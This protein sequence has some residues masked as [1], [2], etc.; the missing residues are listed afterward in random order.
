MFVDSGPDASREAARALFQAAR[1]ER[2]S[3]PATTQSLLTSSGGFRDVVASRARPNEAG[4]AAAAAPGV[5]SI[6]VS[7]NGT[8]VTISWTPSSS[9]DP[10]TSFVLKYSAP[11][12]V[13]GQQ[14][15]SARTVTFGGLSPGQYQ[16]Q[17]YATNSAGTTCSVPVAGEFTIVNAPAVPDPPT[18]LGYSLDGGIVTISWLIASTGAPPITLVVLAEGLGEFPVGLSGGITTSG[19]MPP[20]TYVVRV[21]ARNASGDSRP[22]GPISV[23]VPCTPPAAPQLSKSVSGSSVT[24][25]WS[26]GSPKIYTSSYVVTIS[27]PSPSQ[28]SVGSGTLTYTASSL[29]P[30]DY[31][32]T[33]Q[34]TSGGSC[35]GGAVSTVSFTITSTSQATFTGSFNGT[36][37]N[38]SGSCTWDVN[39]NGTATLNLTLQP[40]GLTLSGTIQVGGN[41]SATSTNSNCKPDSGK[42]GDTKSISGTVN[43]FTASGLTIDFPGNGS[44]SGSVLSTTLA[45]GTLTVSY[46][47]GTGSVVLPITFRR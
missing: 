22:A 14:P 21:L 12:G 42:F 16:V 20:G 13:S 4:I 11:G 26:S 44:F 41:Y 3:A 43:R 47:A 17:I 32:A 9:G 36:G 7:V 18:Q 27:G 45:I 40:D 46:P 39:Y 1:A 6:Q 5:P 37:P 34:A 2:A 35:G 30:G 15:I 29:Q 19:P 23:V 25:N 24:L 10:A 28:V 38:A 31:T 33:V 8:S